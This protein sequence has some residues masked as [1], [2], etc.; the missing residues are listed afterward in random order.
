MSETFAGLKD[1]VIRLVMVFAYFYHWTFTFPTYKANKFGHNDE[2]Q[3]QKCQCIQKSRTIK[4]SVFLCFEISTMQEF[5]SLERSISISC[6]SFYKISCR[7]NAKGKVNNEMLLLV[8]TKDVMLHITY[9]KQYYLL[10][11]II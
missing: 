9:G 2:R 10:L 4:L 6:C 7:N 1:P 8:Q 11:W 3:E 5:F